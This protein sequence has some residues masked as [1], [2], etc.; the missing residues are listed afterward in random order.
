MLWRS[1]SKSLVDSRACSVA[2]SIDISA[3]ISSREFASDAAPSCTWTRRV[4]SAA[5][6][7]SNLDSKRLRRPPTAEATCSTLKLA[8]SAAPSARA[9]A[10]ALVARSPSKAAWSAA[11]APCNLSIS[12]EVLCT[13]CGNSTLQVCMSWSTSCCSACCVAAVATETSWMLLPKS[14]TLCTMCACKSC[15]RSPAPARCFSS[16]LIVS[17]SALKAASCSCASV[18]RSWRCSSDEATASFMT[19][20]DISTTIACA[21]C[22]SHSAKNRSCWAFC[23]C[24]CS[25]STSK[26]ARSSCTSRR[27]SATG[28]PPSSGMRCVR[29]ICSCCSLSMRS[30]FSAQVSSSLSLCCCRDASVEPSSLCLRSSVWKSCFKEAN[31]EACS[32]LLDSHC[33]CICS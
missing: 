16:S 18:L 17:S 14:F 32:S 29:S 1:A 13:N 23:S 10:P 8:P 24:R 28:L 27:T 5:S 22:C 12:P 3:H 30:A 21:L 11:A 6:R 26:S 33:F 9:P 31:S 19:A 20:N 25:L 15:T 2:L 7:P 4:A